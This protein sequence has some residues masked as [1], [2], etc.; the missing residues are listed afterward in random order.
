MSQLPESAT[1]KSGR[2]LTPMSKLPRS[3]GVKPRWPVGERMLSRSGMDGR[4]DADLTDQR[5]EAIERRQHLVGLRRIQIEDQAGHAGLGVA[6][7]E[8]RVLRDAEDRDR[9]ARRIAPGL[10]NQLLEVRQEL[11]D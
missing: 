5:R 6:L 3:I 1:I 9:Q 2:R 8:I 10:G 7:D 4:S 11:D